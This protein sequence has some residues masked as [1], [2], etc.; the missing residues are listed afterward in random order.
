[1][2]EN[3]AR[4]ERD[5]PT[6][7]KH[8]IDMI[9]QGLAVTK[10]ES[11]DRYRVMLLESLRSPETSISVQDLINIANDIGIASPAFVDEGPKD[12]TKLVDGILPTIK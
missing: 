10:P 8:Y 2:R 9:Q 6:L 5:R 12:I 7:M 1:M 11:R 3:L 4:E